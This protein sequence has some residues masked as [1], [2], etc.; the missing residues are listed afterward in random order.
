MAC[1]DVCQHVADRPQDV[2]NKHA[3]PFVPSWMQL[4]TSTPYLDDDQT[5]L[6]C[7]CMLSHLEALRQR[8]AGNQ[9]VIAYKDL[10]IQQLKAQLGQAPAPDTVPQALWDRFL[11]E[12][13]QVQGRKRWVLREH[14]K[15]GL[16]HDE[17]VGE[18]SFTARYVMAKRGL[19]VRKAHDGT[20]GSKPEHWRHGSLTLE[21]ATHGMW[22]CKFDDA[23]ATEEEIDCG[24]KDLYDT[25][26]L[27]PS[28]TGELLLQ[29]T[30]LGYDLASCRDPFTGELF[31]D[32]HS[33]K[34]MNI[35]VTSGT[36]VKEVRDKLETCC[37]CRNGLRM[38]TPLQKVLDP[39]HDERT[40][41]EVLLLPPDDDDVE[42]QVVLEVYVVKPDGTQ[43]MFWRS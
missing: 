34:T 3:E 9:Q 15:C 25:N 13:P 30:N 17:R 20:D 11:A 38:I 18:P 27:P 39:F 4:P 43:E 6:W 2:L 35:Q 32:P 31:K 41:D 1:A 36:T 8:E 37:D 40:L 21:H 42:K 7:M 16:V 10:Q 5:A 29:T 33:G 19:R 23:I 26:P 12:A 22:W 14:S 28:K 24:K